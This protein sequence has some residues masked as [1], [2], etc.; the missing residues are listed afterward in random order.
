[1]G[2]AVDAEEVEGSMDPSGFTGAAPR[3]VRALTSLT[4]S[5]AQEMKLTL[6]SSSTVSTARIPQA[7]PQLELSKTNTRRREQLES[8][9]GN[10]ILA[11]EQQQELLGAPRL[12]RKELCVGGARFATEGPFQLST[13]V[14]DFLRDSPMT[15]PR[16]PRVEEPQCVHRKVK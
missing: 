11:P 8:S 1:M 10:E 16:P 13:L 7:K 9:G 3:A 2:A 4:I 12:S 5:D 6:Q 14:S 15:V